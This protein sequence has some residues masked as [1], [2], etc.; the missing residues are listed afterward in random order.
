MGK[1][2]PEIPGLKTERLNA[3]DVERE[4]RVQIADSDSDHFGE[5]GMVSDVSEGCGCRDGWCRVALDPSKRFPNGT[6]EEFRY[7]YRGDVSDLLKIVREPEREP[8]PFLTDSEAK[9]GAI[10]RVWIGSENNYRDAKRGDGRITEVGGRWASVL[11][12]DG[13]S[14][15]YAFGPGYQE[16]ILVSP[17]KPE[18]P[19]EK[20][21]RLKKEQE[22]A[23]K[24]IGKKLTPE[25]AKP[26][27]R[28]RIAPDSRFSG[29]SRKDG[30][31]RGLD[32]DKDWVR[33]DFDDGYSNRYR[34][35]RK[36]GDSDL[37]LIALAPSKK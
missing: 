36:G 35:G 24:G 31:I 17:A 8:I 13:Y 2:L 16:L 11:F 32:S 6:V 28:V 22:N 37:I 9:E 15:E 3:R 23:K 30:T 19:A 34:Y 27:A 7:G 12:S 5:L 10:V 21:A 33:V 26:K 20:E 1:R 18:T 25:N 14:D 4:L 29:Q